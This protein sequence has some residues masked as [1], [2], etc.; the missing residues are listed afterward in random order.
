M[1]VGYFKYQS[2]MCGRDLI[3]NGDFFHMIITKKYQKS[4][5]YNLCN[6][7][8]LLMKTTL[9]KERISNDIFPKT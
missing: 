4:S 8:G 6:N 1:E 3:G 7:N 5:L 9:C 2:M